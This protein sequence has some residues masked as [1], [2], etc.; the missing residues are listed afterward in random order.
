MNSLI[1][2]TLS[3]TEI[4]NFLDNRCN[5]IPYPKLS[6]Y[7]T[8]YE[9]L[10][11]YQKLVILYLTNTNIGHWCCVWINENGLNFFD[12]YGGSP[13]SQLKLIS[14]H[15][16]KIDGQEYPLLTYLMYKTGLPVYFNEFPLQKLKQN[17]NTCG[18]W[19]CI[20]LKYPDISEDEF[21]NI[22]HNFNID[23]DILITLLTI[24]I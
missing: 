7:S 12:S 22:F 20:R 14:E 4:S 21:Y 18:R 17:I 8:I 23:P 16:T 1:E 5:L 3:G 6:Q 13:D 15:Y 11:K 24:N 10:G 9:A 2:K 19:V